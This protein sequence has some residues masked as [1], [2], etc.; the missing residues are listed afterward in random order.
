MR[1]WTIFTAVAVIVVLAAGWLLLVKPQ[2]SKI[3]DYQAQ[4]QT[5]LQANSVLLTQIEQLQAE[6]SEL[7]QEQRALQKFSTQIPNDAEEPTLIRQFTT[8]AH[9]AGVDL[10]SIGPGAATV[11]SASTAS[12][13]QTLGGATASTVGA[14]NSLPITL[15]VTGS[16]P[17]IESFFESLE[18]LPRALLVTGFSVSPGGVA[19]GATGT[20]PLTVSITAQ[21]FF[22]PPAATTAAP[23]TTAQTL[24]PPTTPATAPAAATTPG[25]T[26]AATT[27][28]VPNAPA[29]TN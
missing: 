3:S 16:Y 4:A 22:T 8:A 28:T 19:T 26:P 17:N 13:A 29:E 25:A 12:G 11:V 7:P 9:G 10:S 20:N 14:L 1:R 2:K 18:K 15:S 21:V 24:T 6:Q 5:Q 27:P 23:G